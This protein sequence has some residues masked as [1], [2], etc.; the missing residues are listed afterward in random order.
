MFSL[1][2]MVYLGI[3]FLQE[4]ALK[5]VKALK[6]YMFYLLNPNILPIL[7]CI[8]DFYSIFLEKKKY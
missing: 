8:I 7:R 5:Q 6:I 2:F 1:G 4:L 3:E